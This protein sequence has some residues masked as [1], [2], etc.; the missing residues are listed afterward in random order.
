LLNTIAAAGT[1]TYVATHARTGDLQTKAT[2]HG[3]ATASVW[4]AGI[5]VLAAL[6]AGGLINVHPRQHGADANAS[7]AEAQL[8]PTEVY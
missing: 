4:V 3:Y 1:A 8:L 7:N 2:V 6:F 5:F